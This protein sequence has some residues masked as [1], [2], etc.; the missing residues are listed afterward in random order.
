[1]YRMCCCLHGGSVVPLKLPAQGENIAEGCFAGEQLQ[2]GFDGL[3]LGGIGPRSHGRIHQRVVNIDI[4]S[5]NLPKAHYAHDMQ[6]LY[7]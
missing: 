6:T 4:G 3:T 1:M 2:A 5:H 7:T